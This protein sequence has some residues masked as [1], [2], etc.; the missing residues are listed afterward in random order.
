LIH[1][2]VCVGTQSGDMSAMLGGIVKGL[3]SKSSHQVT[4]LTGAGEH[5]IP[6][7]RPDR[8]PGQDS[9]SE[10]SGRPVRA[11]PPAPQVSGGKVEIGV[12]TSALSEEEFNRKR[13][14]FRMVRAAPLQLS[15]TA[16]PPSP[17]LFGH[18]QSR[19]H[20]LRH[21]APSTIGFSTR[22]PAILKDGCLSLMC[23][24]DFCHSRTFFTV[25]P[26]PKFR[27][28]RSLFPSDHM[29]LFKKHVVVWGCG[30]FWHTRDS[31]YLVS[32]KTRH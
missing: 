9:A 30:R 3:R 12:D 28:P 4:P 23:S 27:T 22:L 18:S 26:L 32:L 25:R 24:M 10:L 13:V 8:D 29:V 7:H 20:A 1:L 16:Q 21:V 6:R 31:L 5:S 19:P 14:G 15:I 2:E 11:R 17:N